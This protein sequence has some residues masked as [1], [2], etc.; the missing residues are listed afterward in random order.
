[1]P[2]GLIVWGGK[3]LA[4]AAHALWA[5]TAVAGTHGA[6]VHG[7]HGALIGSA[8]GGAVAQL[9]GAGVH[10]TASQAF[11]GAAKEV[12]NQAISSATQA[13]QASGVHITAAVLPH[14]GQHA[15]AT[16]LGLNQL[17]TPEVGIGAAALVGDHVAGD[18]LDDKIA[19][20]GSLI[21]N[22][23]KVTAHALAT[24]LKLDVNGES[25]ERVVRRATAEGHLLPVTKEVFHV[26]PTGH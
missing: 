9:H 26:T 13:A 6:L 12:A 18:W 17:L 1:M 19:E 3:A 10:A 21:K 7:T 14:A 20:L 24:Q 5:H 4:G 25:F 8:K 16:G 23:S 22:R 2:L 11:H 15:A